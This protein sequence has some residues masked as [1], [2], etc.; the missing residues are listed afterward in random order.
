MKHSKDIKAA[1]DLAAAEKREFS[2]FDYITNAD[3]LSSLQR[4][5]YM[6]LKARLVPLVIG[7]FGIGKTASIEHLANLMNLKLID[8][9]LATT[10]LTVLSGYPMKVERMVGDQ[11]VT[12]ATHMIDEMFPIQGTEKPYHLNSDGTFVLD[13]EGNKVQYDGWLMLFGEITSVVPS[14]QS[15][16]YKI[17]NERKVGNLK[18]DDDCLIICDGNRAI[19]AGAQKLTEGFLTRCT[20]INAK[21][22][23]SDWLH[24]ATVNHIHPQIVSYIESRKDKLDQYSDDV[25]K[26]AS[27]SN[28]AIARTWANLSELMYENPEW[29]KEEQRVLSVG[30]IGEAAYIDFRVYLDYFDDLPDIDDVLENPSTATLPTQGG[31][32]YA[33]KSILQSEIEYDVSAIPAAIEYMDRFEQ[34]ELII[35]LIVGLLAK[36]DN[37]LDDEHKQGDKSGKLLDWLRSNKNLATKIQS[38]KKILK[39]K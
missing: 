11:C 17:T 38:F 2:F 4:Q 8:I 32:R 3:N 14:K 18:L 16:A 12:Y 27:Q 10:D 5:I 33:M 21:L 29:T 22:E 19:D 1:K 37:I 39:V 7:K 15:A 9:R 25:N 35:S 30:T 13:K 20:V 34:P 6:V 31:H 36:N 24:W 26:R 23:P 28:F